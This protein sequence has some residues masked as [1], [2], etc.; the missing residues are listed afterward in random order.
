MSSQQSSPTAAAATTEEF[1]ARRVVAGAPTR[2]Q[3]RLAPEFTSTEAVHDK[4]LRSAA[5]ALG[6]LATLTTVR[7]VVA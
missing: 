6:V 1:G 5:M 7:R 4:V 3:A 2:R